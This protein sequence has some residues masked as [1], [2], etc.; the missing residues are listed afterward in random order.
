MIYLKYDS[1]QDSTTVGM[2]QLKYVTPINEDEISDDTS[3]DEESD[4]LADDVY[5]FIVAAPILSKPFIFAIY[6]ILVKYLVYS[7]LAS[8]IEAKDLNDSDPVV[9]VVKFFLI[10]VAIAMQEDLIHVY[11]SAANIVYDEEALKVSISATKCKLI[12]SF[13]LRFIDGLLSLA[14][15]FAVMLVTDGV[16]AVFLNF[17]ALHFLQSID[18][19]FFG[20]VEKG[21][22]GDEMEHMSNLC[23]Q[24]S[25]PRRTSESG[26]VK[27]V[28]SI[29]FFLTLAICIAIYGVVVSMLVL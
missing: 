11:A 28:D 16:L 27:S 1:K 2:P 6:V 24:I 26:C 23:K 3:G 14:V 29:L 20:L 10:P 15:N 4:P 5:A 17:A 13:M 7:I 22:F 8:G 21:F 12:F 18:D 9:Q 25:F 19:V